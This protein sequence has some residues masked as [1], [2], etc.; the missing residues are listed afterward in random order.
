MREN[1]SGSLRYLGPALL[2]FTLHNNPSK[3]IL[4]LQS[5]FETPLTWKRGDKCCNNE[6]PR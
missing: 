4:L 2:C 6:D 5:G 1:N 3:K